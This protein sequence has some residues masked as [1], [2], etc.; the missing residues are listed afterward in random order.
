[1]MKNCL[2][3]T[4]QTDDFEGLYIPTLNHTGFMLTKLDPFLERFVNHTITE[5]DYFHMDVGAAFG[6][7]TLKAS[8]LGAKMIANDLDQEHLDQIKKQVSTRHSLRTMQGD[9]RYDIEVE[10]ESLGSVLFSRVL[11]FFSGPEILETIQKIYQWLVP[12]G[13]IFCVNETPYFGTFKNF[14]PTYEDRKKRNHPWP[15]Y[16]NESEAQRYIDDSKRPYV[17]SGVHLFDENLYQ[18]IAQTLPFL[19]FQIGY[20]DRKGYFPDDALYDGRESIWMIAQKPLV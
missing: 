17:R 5:K 9:I 8:S 6:S 13:F 16:M 2:A 14:I 19:T 1:M 20:L 15:G 7:V 10:K 18:S 4:P 3:S 12:G 11:H